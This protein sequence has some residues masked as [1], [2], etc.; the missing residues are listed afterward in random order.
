VHVTHD[1]EEAMTMADTIA[2]M[3]HGVIEQLGEPAEL[4]DSPATTFVSNFLGQSNL[5]KAEVVGH[6]GHD[7]IV[8]AHGSKLGAPAA[9]AR[10]TSGTVWVG[11][12]PEKVFLAG[13]DSEPGQ[14][15]NLLSGG[16]VSD[17]SFIGVSTQYLVRMPW[18]QELTVF[19][20]NSGARDGFRVGDPVDLHWTSA[21]TFLLDADQDAHAGDESYAA[22]SGGAAT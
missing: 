2:V 19:E 1:Q 17:V 16:T 13:A 7:I 4:Y 3:N 9:R 8:D 21:H 18:G 6:D 20:Q 10:R 15:G 22:L 14:G 5:V 12:R 11:V